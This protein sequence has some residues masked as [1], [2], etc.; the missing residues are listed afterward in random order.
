MEKQDAIEKFVEA[1]SK[2]V[3]KVIS[4]FIMA[5]PAKYA[6]NEVLNTMFDV[7]VITYWKMF[8]LILLINILN[9]FK[10]TKP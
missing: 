3:G 6:W 7:P 9:P 2:L 8:G 5:W 10:F 1:I 4:I